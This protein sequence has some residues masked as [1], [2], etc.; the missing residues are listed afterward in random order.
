MKEYFYFVDKDGWR[1]WLEQNHTTRNEV[2]LVR[3]MKH[4]G[5]TGITHQDAVDE[6]LCFGWIDGLLR[7]IDD[8]KF[9]QRYSLRKKDGYWSEANK[10]SAS[11]MIIQGRMTETGLEIFKQAVE[12]GECDATMLRRSSDIPADLETALATNKQAQDYFRKFPSLRRKQLIWRITHSNSIQM[13]R[14]R[15]NET[16]RLAEQNKYKSDKSD[17]DEVNLKNRMKHKPK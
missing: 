15:I 7:D 5:K 16:V 10:K 6:A 1:K 17:D 9:V 11:N 4:T 8:E 3:Y 12:S 14:D 13:R 2:W